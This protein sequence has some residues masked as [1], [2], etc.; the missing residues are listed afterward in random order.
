MTAADLALF[1]QALLDGGRALAGVELFSPATL[2]AART[3]RTGD[4][5]DPVFGKRVHRALGIVIAGDHE[6]TYRGFGHTNSE[7]A[8]GHNGAGGQLAWADPVTGLSL[9]YC[10]NG[11]DRNVVRQ[12]RRG[13]GISSRAASCAS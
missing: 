4:L 8:F 5:L 2:A 3:V 13:V 6:R 12:A 11:H 9:G 10:T 7:A 1:H